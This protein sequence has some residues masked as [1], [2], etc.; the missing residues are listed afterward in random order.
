MSSLLIQGI[1]L[2]DLAKTYGTPLYVYDA[3]KI[4][5]QVHTLRA[6]FSSLPVRLLYA[7]KALSTQAILQLM[8]RLGTGLDAVSIQEVQLGLLAGFSPSD[9]LFTPNGVSFEEI[10]QAVQ[11]GVRINIDNISLL[12]QFGHQYGSSVPCCVRLNPHILAGGHAKISTGHIDSKFGISIL[13]LRHLKRVIQSWGIR[14][15]GL[16]VHTGSDILDANAFLE[17]AR[18]L[19][20]VGVEFPELEFIDFGSGFKVAYRPGDITTDVNGLAESLKAEYEAFLRSYGRPVEIWFE[21]GKFFVSEA[22]YL[23]VQ[24]NVVKST[25]AAVFV[26]VNSGL[27]HLIRPMF[28]D[29]YHDIVNLSRTSGPQRVY[30]IV[31]YICETDTFGSDRLLHEVQEGDIL[32]I[33][34]AGAYGFTMSS[35]YNSRL[36]PAEVLVY[37]GRPY[38]IRRAETLED[39][40]RTQYLSIW[41]EIEAS[42][43]GA[44]PEN[45]LS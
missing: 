30:T 40:L 17:M 9:I 22:G 37:R 8:H 19:F 5:H 15:N 33:K 16:H 34:N 26:G 41:E 28:Y 25:P 29:A 2:I 36:R 1:P 12:E 3:E 27:N 20:E 31:G 11:L 38:L 4:A 43:A 21:P 7:A 35:N 44:Y 6:A 18:L 45:R 10:A 23:L 42:L 13:Q 24:V 14:I 39:L 32:A